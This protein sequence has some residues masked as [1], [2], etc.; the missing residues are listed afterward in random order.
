MGAECKLLLPGQCIL[1]RSGFT[2]Y[3]VKLNNRKILLA[4]TANAGI[5]EEKIPHTLRALDKLHKIGYGCH[6]AFNFDTDGSPLRTARP[7]TSF[8]ELNKTPL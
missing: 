7:L 5:P 4:Q 2:D 3:K 1:E 6:S 8:R